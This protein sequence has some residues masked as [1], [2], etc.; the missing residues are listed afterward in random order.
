MGLDGAKLGFVETDGM[1]YDRENS[2]GYAQYTIEIDDDPEKPL[3]TGNQTCVFLKRSGDHWNYVE[4]RHMC[5]IVIKS[6]IRVS[7]ERY[8]MWPLYHKLSQLL[9]I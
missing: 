5:A 2:S 4:L 8:P 3:L 1:R 7:V 6:S 9:N